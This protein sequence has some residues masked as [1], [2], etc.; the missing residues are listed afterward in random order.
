MTIGCPS[1]NTHH[2]WK[3]KDKDVKNVYM[4]TV[5]EYVSTWY[6]RLPNSFIM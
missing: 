6:I 5:I 4:F 3:K 1:T 2:D